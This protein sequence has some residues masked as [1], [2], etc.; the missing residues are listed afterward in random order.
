MGTSLPVA[1]AG[2]LFAARSAATVLMAPRLVDEQG[3]MPLSKWLD[4]GKSVV[5]DVVLDSH[6]DDAPWT[7]VLTDNVDQASQL[8]RQHPGVFAVALDWAGPVVPDL[9]L[10][11][12]S[13]IMSVTGHPESEPIYGV[14]SRLSYGAGAYV[15]GVTSLRLA[16]LRGRHSA[17]AEER[18]LVVEVARV[19]QLVGDQYNAPALQ[20]GYVQRRTGRLNVPQRP[21]GM[22]RCLDGWV[23]IYARLPA[24]WSRL[25]K[26]LDMADLLDDPRLASVQGRLE[27]QEVIDER[28]NHWLSSRTQQEVLAVARQAQLPSAPV[29]TPQAAFEIHRDGLG[30]RRLWQAPI[31]DP[32]CSPSHSEPVEDPQMLVS[33]LRVLELTTGWAGP[34]VGRV[35]AAFGAEVIKV[36]SFTTRDSW[37]GEAAP[38]SPSPFYPDSDPGDSPLDRNVLFNTVNR[39]KRGCALDLNSDE[40]RSRFIELVRGCDVVLENLKP[41]ALTKLGI[42]FD[43]LLEANPTLTMLSISA[44]SE[45]DPLTGWG[46]TV[47]SLSGMASRLGY[48]TGPPMN[49]GLA[50][51]DPLTGI[52]GLAML[53]A[54][55]AFGSRPAYVS[56]SLLEAALAFFPEPRLDTAFDQRLGNGHPY[57]F[58]HGCFDLGDDEWLCVAATSEDHRQQLKRV[59]GMGLML[60]DDA[61]QWNLELGI[62]LRDLRST[63]ELQGAIEELCT[64]GV[65]VSPVLNF[66]DALSVARA[67]KDLTIA[68]HPIAGTQEYPLL[69]AEPAEASAQRRAPCLGEHPPTWGDIN[70][71]TQTSLEDTH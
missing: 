34:T 4:A 71:T 64:F 12:R 44:V 40:G 49:T 6:L 41:G 33:P 27:H 46:P 68:D 53:T 66:A 55:L 38:T 39:G 10:S 18:M 56:T 13:G 45:F 5:S 42:G 59:L 36:E 19:A 58:P 67:R 24:E 47:E 21:T 7:V 15:F 3:S 8:A 22:Y 52:W 29:L 26:S 1:F 25:A 31:I 23:L 70:S 37:R 65:P 20:S 16:Q 14:G 43:T 54:E 50:A 11:A 35:L 63:D 51:L 57:W 60:N 69:P 2:K 32:N 48:P 9:I 62:R 61:E 30:D 28:V 17:S